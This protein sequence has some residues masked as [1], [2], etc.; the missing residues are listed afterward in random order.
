M[1]GD[2]YST[3]IPV[4]SL[5]IDI[6]LDE[7]YENLFT[8]QTIEQGKRCTGNSDAFRH[9]EHSFG[10]LFSGLIGGHTSSYPT[11]YL[12]KQMEIQDEDCQT[13]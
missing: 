13:A 6:L 2:V 11:T 5:G 1:K 8:G 3:V 7:W 10:G 9:P 12:N 4:S